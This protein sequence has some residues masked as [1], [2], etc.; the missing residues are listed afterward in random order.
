MG[1]KTD[2]G[3]NSAEDY[4]DRIERKTKRIQNAQLIL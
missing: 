4:P 2:L 3:I 1:K